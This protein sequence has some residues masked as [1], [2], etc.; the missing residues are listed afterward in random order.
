[1]KCPKCEREW[2]DEC[3]QAECVRR[4]GECICCR[5]LPRGAKNLHGSGAGTDAEFTALNSALGRGVDMAKPGDDRTT[6]YPL[7]PNNQGNRHKPA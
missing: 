7:P 5:F 6:Y 3:Q 2:P 1:M 4:H